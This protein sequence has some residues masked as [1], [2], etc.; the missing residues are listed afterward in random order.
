MIHHNNI[1]N[2]K[3]VIYSVLSKYPC[4]VR[5]LN[6]IIIEFKVKTTYEVTIIDE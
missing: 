3:N 2:K 1:S 6:N 4:S 5:I